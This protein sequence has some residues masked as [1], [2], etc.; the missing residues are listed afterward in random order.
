MINISIDVHAYV[1]MSIVYLY[2]L[3]YI[4]VYDHYHIKRLQSFHAILSLRLESLD[5][6]TH[7]TKSSPTPARRCSERHDE[8]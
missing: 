8:T 6:S 3:I 7:R 1:Y 2:Y 4:Y 5:S